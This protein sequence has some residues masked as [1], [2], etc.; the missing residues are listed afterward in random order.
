MCLCAVHLLSRSSPSLLCTSEIVAFFARA[1]V[2]FVLYHCDPSGFLVE[3]S[4]GPQPLNHLVSKLLRMR[5]HVYVRSR[6]HHDIV[7]LNVF[8]P[9]LSKYVQQS[10]R[11]TGDLFI[12]RTSLFFYL[13]L[14][15]GVQTGLHYGTNF[16]CAQ[17]PFRQGIQ[18]Q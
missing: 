15:A 8:D 16:P 14:P 11:L 1:V 3:L 13:S 9:F 5:I 12:D 18:S 6:P 2:Q 10:R 4:V 7:H 17:C